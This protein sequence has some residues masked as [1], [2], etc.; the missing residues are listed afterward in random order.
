L[1][2]VGQVERAG[3]WFGGLGCLAEQDLG[4]GVGDDGLAELG[5]E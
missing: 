4:S 1:L 5:A 3:E 2:A